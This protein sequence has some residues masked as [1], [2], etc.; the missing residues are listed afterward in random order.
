MNTVGVLDASG[1]ISARRAPAAAQPG[2]AIVAIL[3]LALGI[4][5]NTA[6]FSLVNAFLLRSLPVRNPDEL[7]LFRAVEGVNGRMS[8]AGENNGS[9][10]PATGRNST[11]VV[12]AADLRTLPRP[13]VRRCRRSSPSRRSRSP[14]CSS[15]A[16][17]RLRRIGAA[18]VRQLPRRPWRAGA[19]R[20]HVHDG[21]R[22]AFRARRSPSSRFATGSA[23]FGRDPGV[24]GKTIAVNRVPDDHRRRDAAGFR[25]RGAGGR[26]ARHLAAARAPPARFSRTAPI[27]TQP[28]YWWLR[29]MGRLAPGATPAQ[30]RARARAGL[31]GG[32]ARRLARGPGSRRDATRHAGRFN[33]GRR[34][35]RAGREQHAA[36][37]CAGRSTS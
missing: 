25:R 6:I 7:V 2:F 5:A 11:H 31:P 20:P 32:G 37:V 27:A 34:P 10:D 1:A 12:L 9:I 15:T 23:R 24:I 14:T 3:S 35:R 36:A 22:P 18:G 29:V 26:V 30:A 19:A 17:R 33:A 8:R 21:R 13:A 16:S 28:W 4:G